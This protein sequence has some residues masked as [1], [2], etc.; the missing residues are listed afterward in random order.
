MMSALCRRARSY[1]EKVT[2]VATSPIIVPTAGGPAPGATDYEVKITLTEEFP[3][4]RS[5]LSASTEI[6]TA[7]RENVLAIPIQ[8]LV[9]RSVSDDSASAAGV[10]E[11]EGVFVV[12]DGEAVFVPVRVGISG[13]RYF[14]VLSGLEE[15][16]QVVSGSYEALRDLTDGAP[17]K[18]EEAAASSEGS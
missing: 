14:E 1:A 16:D 12:R 17:V 8:S 13:D 5:G 4:P 9:V 10:V 3:S 11:K 6:V 18:I 2:E 7:R 15:G